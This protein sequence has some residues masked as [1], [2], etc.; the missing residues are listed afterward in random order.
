MHS[1]LPG[2][3]LHFALSQPKYEKATLTQYF[4]ADNKYSYHVDNFTLL[5]IQ[6]VKKGIAVSPV[7]IFSKLENFPSSY[8]KPSCP[9]DFLLIPK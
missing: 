3:H 8:L 1:Q 6:Y 4:Y 7:G 5:T 9:T 2:L